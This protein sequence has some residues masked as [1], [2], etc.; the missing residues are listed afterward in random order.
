MPC[1]TDRR[2][3]REDSDMGKFQ[4]LSVSFWAPSFSAVHSDS[5]I[6]SIPGLV[7]LGPIISQSGLATIV[8]H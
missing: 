1:T 8:Q 7:G 4:A 5:S 3:H 6:E 2:C